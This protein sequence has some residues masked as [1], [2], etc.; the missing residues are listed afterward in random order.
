MIRV[1]ENETQL[2][3]RSCEVKEYNSIVLKMQAMKSMTPSTSTYNV[4]STVS[5]T[6]SMGVS[7]QDHVRFIV[8]EGTRGCVW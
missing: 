4:W 3:V 1:G 2:R 7:A 6:D 5:F 8:N